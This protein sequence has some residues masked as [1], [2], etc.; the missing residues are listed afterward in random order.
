M[1][2]IRKYTVVALFGVLL[3]LLGVRVLQASPLPDTNKYLNVGR[4]V[5]TVYFRAEDTRVA[6]DYLDWAEA[7]RPRP[8]W[9]SADILHSLSI[10]IAPSQEEFTALS[11]GLL[12][13]WGVACA[14]PGT[15]VVIVRSPRIVELW[16]EAPREIL[17]HEITHIF[18]DQYLAGA[19]VP[20]WFH[21]GYALYAS[22]MW[23]LE[24]FLRFSVA[25]L[26]GRVFSLRELE[27]GMPE[28][29]EWAE[30]AYIQSYTVVEFMFEYW[31]DAQ[32]QLLFERW[33]AT[34]EL[35]MALRS[36]VGL[37]LS[38]ME[39]KWRKWAGVRYGWL[40]LLT[41]ATLMW[42]VAA[43]LFLVVFARRR[44]SNKRK[45]EE[46]RRRE[47]WLLESSMPAGPN[48]LG[49]PGAGEQ[50]IE[51]DKGIT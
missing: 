40:K 20:R 43:L 28:N 44:G 2:F 26:S 34:G 38:R 47:S 50:G 48:M 41:S 13:E 19:E 8:E 1:L 14:I 12:P 7:Y 39:E 29:E 32:M 17:N 11:G 4:G 10:Y 25:V 42:I 37:T 18:L 22:R 5:N 23:D 6:R 46:M 15:D 45:L 36:S 3:V 27:R 21:E 16:R 35:D 9:L 30:L 51:R 31:D 24:S 33:R 49:E